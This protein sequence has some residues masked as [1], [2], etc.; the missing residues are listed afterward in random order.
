MSDF[1][2]RYSKVRG[3]DHVKN[4]QF[5]GRIAAQIKTVRQNRSLSQQQLADLAGVPKS[6]IGRIEA[7]LTS[8]KVE[9]LLLLSKAL[10]TPFI[11]DGTM[12]NNDHSL[13]LRT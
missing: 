5:E 2:K 10:D 8:P 3:E 12:D 4:L 9:T 13:Y 11:I 6:T 1:F 7:G